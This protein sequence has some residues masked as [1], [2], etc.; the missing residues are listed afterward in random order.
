MTTLSG[1]G[2]KRN[3]R[4]ALPILAFVSSL[5]LLGAIGIFVLELVSFSQQQNRLPADVTVAGIPVGGQLPGEAIATWERAL[6]Q[7]I[8]LWYKDSPI[9]L[10][11]SA[12]GLR[13]SSETMLAEAQ[14][15]SEAGGGNWGRFFNYLTGRISQTP[16]Q[17]GLS[18]D[19]QQSLLEQFLQDISLRYDRAPGTGGY[20]VQTL[21]IRPGE[22]GQILNIRQALP[23][24]DAA[25]HSADNRSV[26]L[27]VSGTEPG[28]SSITVLENMIKAYLDSEGFLYDGQTTVASVYIQDLQ[29][30]EEVNLL[31]D[32]AFSAASTIKIPILIDYFRTLN[33]PPTDEEAFL[34]ANSLL[35]SNN[36]SSNLIMQ[37]IG[38]G[39][40]IFRGLTD[41]TETAQ[42]LGARNTY[43]TAP[44]ITGAD[45]DQFGSVPAPATSPNPN[46]NTGPDPFNQTTPEDL[47]TLMS[48]V[49]DCA[50][51]G[52]GL[53]AAY[54]DG[55][56]TQTECRQM[57]ELM[58][59]NDLLR[60]LQGGIPPET[61]ISHKNGWLENV[62]GDAGIV[63]PPNGR[64][65]VIAV[66]LWEDT[67][68]FSFERAWPLIEGISRAAWNYFSPETP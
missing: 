20:D 39:S 28:S 48:M 66:F 23:M 56:Y 5:L 40:D 16:V 43:I 68:F 52:S 18:A 64:N 38:G 67:D 22:G 51:F 57:L 42:Y 65:Y 47:G 10:D 2:T 63:Y 59:A 31:G 54:P 14:A 4:R 30:G 26:Q 15:A 60:L 37:I 44:F 32:V 17:V 7:P 53:M 25:L 50:N 35:C 41:V 13:I 9:L 55:E 12:L 61:R 1:L 6:S 8:T 24:I 58:S 45:T 27:P 33:L 11:P 36:S 19:Y 46:H 49:Y 29:T 62:H 21:T 34:M 3:R